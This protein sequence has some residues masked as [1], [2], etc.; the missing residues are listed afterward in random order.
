MVH[1]IDNELPPSYG[2]SRAMGFKPFYLC[3]K[4]DTYSKFKKEIKKIKPLL[5]SKQTT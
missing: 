1:L 4:P 5:V 3:N 2:Q